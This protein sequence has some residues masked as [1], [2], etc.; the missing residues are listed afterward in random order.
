MII[1]IGTDIVDMS[2]ISRL[3]NLY[4]EKFITRILTKNELKKFLNILEINK[5]NYIAKR[6]AG[7]EAF[8]KALGLGIGKPI[9]FNDIEI[10]ND[11]LGK[12]YLSLNSNQHLIKNY[13]IDISLSDDSLYS[14]AFVVISSFN[15][16]YLK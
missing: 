11:D 4:Q 13:S 10:L 15:N 6:F 16:E 2:R 12:P 5:V 14:I 7:K 3:I 8:S 9:N 1:G